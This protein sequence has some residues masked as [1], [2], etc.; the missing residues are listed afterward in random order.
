VSV[1]P[2]VSIIVSVDSADDGG[3]CGG[4]T[5]RPAL[6]RL[7]ADI[8]ERRIDIVVVYKVDRLTCAGLRA[9]PEP[10]KLPAARAL[11][12]CRTPGGPQRRRGLRRLVLGVEGVE[13]LVEAILT[14]ITRPGGDAGQ[15]LRSP[16]GRLERDRCWAG[17]E[18]E[19][20]NPTG[21]TDRQEQRK[22]AATPHK[23]VSIRA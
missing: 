16:L 21:C 2:A 23:I 17:T 10:G 14:I 8:R 5:E 19:E 20:S 13:L 18:K 1:G 15:R 11:C 12:C 22:A 7:L 4:S 3:Y 6:Q 9:L